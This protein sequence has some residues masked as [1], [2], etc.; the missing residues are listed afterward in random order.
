MNIPASALDEFSDDIASLWCASRCASSPSSDCLS[1]ANQTLVIDRS[2]L[3]EGSSVATGNEHRESSC[4]IP[5][6]AKPPSSLHFL[7]DYVSMSRPCIIRNAILVPTSPSRDQH[8]TLR[9]LDEPELPDSHRVPLHI[10]LDDLVQ[11]D[12]NAALTVAVTPDGHGDCVRKVS[13]C[14]AKGTADPE[15]VFVEPA[16]W[17]MTLSEFRHLIRTTRGANSEKPD[18]SE[19]A[20]SCCSVADR[21][22]RGVS[23][24][25]EIDVKNCVEPSDTT[26]NCGDPYSL[27]YSRQNDCLRQEL[28]TLHGVSGCSP[29]PS[30]I[31]WAEEAFGVGP[32]EAINMWIGNET[33]VSAIHKDHYENLFY[34]LSGEKIFTLYPPGDVCFLTENKYRSGRFVYC[35]NNESGRH[36]W[37][38][39]YSPDA[40]VATEGADKAASYL[41]S[42]GTSTRWISNS[43]TDDRTELTTNPPTGSAH[44]V[45]VR[46]EAGDMLYLPA[47]WFH[48]VTQW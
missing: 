12:P 34:V 5:I 43:G 25:D 28:T 6:L 18:A 41:I 33:N 40:D 7:R 46:L 14:S 45:Q 8:G 31:P 24:D 35:A 17:T 23:L 39:Q 37:R 3:C 32:P 29:F 19:T 26:R 16:E 21:V 36:E 48:H 15:P 10:S 9:D 27:Y 47:L 4:P 2:A 13:D 11:M 42:Q 1:V 44:P 22:F 20:V 30:T 38:V